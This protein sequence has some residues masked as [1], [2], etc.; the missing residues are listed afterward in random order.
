MQKMGS[1]Q[2]HRSMFTVQLADPCS[3]ELG[4]PQYI[5]AQ[6]DASTTNLTYLISAP[7]DDDSPAEVVVSFLSPITPTSSLR[8]AIPASY[9]SI[10]VQGNFDIDVYMDVNGDWVSGDNNKHIKWFHQSVEFDD[11]GSL[12]TWQVQ[13]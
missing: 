6:Y 11:T 3:F 7:D 4:Y 9:I 1:K 8:Q 2:C 5:G 12:W 13:K 10:T